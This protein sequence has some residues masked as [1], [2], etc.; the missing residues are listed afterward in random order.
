MLADSFDTHG[1]GNHLTLQ[2]KRRKEEE[3]RKKR[4]TR[5]SNVIREKRDDIKKTRNKSK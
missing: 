2:K 4:K 5:P 1:N 3:K